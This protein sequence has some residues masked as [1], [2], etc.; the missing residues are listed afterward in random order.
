MMPSVGWRRVG[1]NGLKFSAMVPVAPL[2]MVMELALLTAGLDEHPVTASAVPAR[3][4]VKARPSLFFFCWDLNCI[5]GPFLLIATCVTIARH[6]PFC[7]ER[8]LSRARALAREA[9]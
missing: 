7:Q 2:K 1:E 8:M 3:T 6:V 9:C 4:A 5:F